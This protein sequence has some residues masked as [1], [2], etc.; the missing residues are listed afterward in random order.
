M[1]KFHKCEKSN[2]NKADAPNHVLKNFSCT[3]FENND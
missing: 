1:I 3:L 2:D